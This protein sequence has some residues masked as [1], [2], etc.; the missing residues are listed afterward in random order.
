MAQSLRENPLKSFPSDIEKNPKQCM[1]ITLRSGKEMDEPK[2][3]EK[4]E[5]QV[6]HKNMEVEEKIEDEE[7]IVGVEL[8]N[9]GNEQKYVVVVP[10]RMNFPD[11]PPLYTPPL[12]FPQR[13]QKNQAG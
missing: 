2:K 7:N 12:P 10:R 3:D 6:E 5:K 11:N 4:T 1:V 9:K 13:Y 8:N